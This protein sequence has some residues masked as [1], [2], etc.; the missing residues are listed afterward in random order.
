MA[1]RDRESGVV[2]VVHGRRRLHGEPEHRCLL[3]HRVIERQV[4]AVQVDGS[5]QRALGPR[6]AGHVINVR[7][8]QQDVADVQVRAVDNVEEQVDLVTRVD[9]HA[10]PGFL[11]GEHV[12]ILVERGSLADLEEHLGMINRIK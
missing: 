3:Q 11:A 1:E 7:V 12:A 5:A 10:V 2:V 4:V 6:R 9:D 8:R